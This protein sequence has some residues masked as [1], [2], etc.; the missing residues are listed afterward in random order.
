MNI[1]EKLHNLTFFASVNVNDFTEIVDEFRN[2]ILEACNAG[3]LDK[4]RKLAAGSKFKL[5]I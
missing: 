1:D 3:D 5:R 4:V 2:K